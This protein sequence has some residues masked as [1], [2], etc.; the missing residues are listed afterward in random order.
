MKLLEVHIEAEDPM[1]TL[2]LYKKLLPYKEVRQWGD[3]IAA[4]IFWD[5]TAFGIWP[6]GS[7]GIHNGRAGSHVH[8]AWQIEDAWYDSTVIKIRDAGLDPL[9]H[10]WPNGKKSV[11][12]FDYDGNQGEFMTCD[13]LKT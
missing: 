1:R 5:G 6:K 11:Y 9:E 13:W 4:L 2:E 10:E 3:G 8:F 12:F 7:R